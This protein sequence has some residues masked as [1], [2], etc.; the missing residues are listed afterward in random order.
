MKLLN[1][2]IIATGFLLTFSSVG[3]VF[4]VNESRNDALR[5]SAKI[6]AEHRYESAIEACE[7]GNVL[8]EKINI[9]IDGSKG[10]Q[11]P[12]VD[13]RKVIPQPEP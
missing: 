1:L 13:C 2:A 6:E 3:A 12:L 4:L 8:R 9:L 7:R 11:I 10:D 5:K